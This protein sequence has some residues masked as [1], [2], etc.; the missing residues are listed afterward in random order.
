MFV[1]VGG[2][3]PARVLL[4][5]VVV[6]LVVVMMMMMAVVV[7]VHRL[8]SRLPRAAAGPAICA[9]GGRPLLRRRT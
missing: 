4:S 1:P 5:V 3:I 7:H 6:V 2:G 8:L 9:L